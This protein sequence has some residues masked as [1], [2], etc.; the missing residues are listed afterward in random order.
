MLIVQYQCSFRFL[1]S[2]H[3]REFLAESK[4]ECIENNV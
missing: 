1:T 2:A 4:I 3:K